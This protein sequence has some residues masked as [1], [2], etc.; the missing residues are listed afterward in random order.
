MIQLII[1][2]II[3]A[4]AAGIAGYRLYRFI[5]DPF[6]KCDGCSKG[7]SGCAIDEL[8]KEIDKKRITRKVIHD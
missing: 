4:V 7:C 2:L 1:A 5:R 3:V 8:K 6:S